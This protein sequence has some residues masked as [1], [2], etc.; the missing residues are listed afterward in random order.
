M[1]INNVDDLNQNQ[2]VLKAISAMRVDFSTK[3]EGVLTGI[4]E[5]KRDLQAYSTRLDEAE[6]R[7]STV[8][9]TVV[10]VKTTTEQLKIQVADLT[11]KLNSLKNHQRRSSLRLVNLPEKVHFLRDGFQRHWGRTSFRTTC[12]IKEPIGFRFLQA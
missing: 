8:E 6:E 4:D 10:T 3:L 9:D 2:R 11:S 1:T 7:I 5:V 12:A